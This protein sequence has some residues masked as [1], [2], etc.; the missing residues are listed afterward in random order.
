MTEEKKEKDAVVKT[1]KTVVDFDFP[2]AFRSLLGHLLPERE[3][4]NQIRDEALK[5]IREK[6]TQICI[7]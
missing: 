3:D 7:Y 4:D 2:A 5:F 1:L 6:V